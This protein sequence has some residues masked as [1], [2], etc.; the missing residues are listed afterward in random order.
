MRVS[1]LQPKIKRG[2]VEQNLET[3][4]RLMKRSIGDLLILP[5]Y[6]LTGSLVLDK[7]ANVH[8]WAARCREAKTQIH[9]IEGARA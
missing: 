5:E 2:N 3:I 4:Q 7:E 6:V 9:I 8:D 1:L